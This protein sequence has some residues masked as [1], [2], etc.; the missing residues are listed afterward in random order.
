MKR[1]ECYQKEKT[2]S[3]QHRPP[4]GSTSTCWCM[5]LGLGLALPPQPQQGTQHH[6]A[7]GDGL[8]QEA[9]P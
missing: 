2:P 5:C 6:G 9:L 7:R 1:D 8:I 3:G 4:G